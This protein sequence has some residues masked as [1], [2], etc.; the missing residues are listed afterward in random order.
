MARLSRGGGLDGEAREPARSERSTR[1]RRART[2][3]TLLKAMWL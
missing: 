2:A 1:R 3:L